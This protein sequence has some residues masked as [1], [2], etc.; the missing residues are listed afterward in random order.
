MG[1]WVIYL[2]SSQA[3]RFQ[4]K[5]LP[6][7]DVTLTITIFKSNA[8]VLTNLVAL[9]SLANLL[10]HSLSSSIYISRVYYWF[11]FYCVAWRA[12]MSNTDDLY[13][14]VK[15]TCPFVRVVRIVYCIHES[16][17]TRACVTRSLSYM[18]LPVHRKVPVAVDS[19]ES[20]GSSN[21][22]TSRCR[23]V[24]IITVSLNAHGRLSIPRSTKN[25]AWIAHG[26][27][28]IPR[29]TKN[30]AWIAHGRMSIPRSTKNNA[31]NAHRRMNIP[32]STKN[33]AWNA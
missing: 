10:K 33:Y 2:G 5:T 16:L 19:Y 15:L 20:Y 8:K 9:D 3:V 30:N 18:T 4:G 29:S 1:G 28:S 17:S 22:F 27:M 31:W 12:R 13:R 6:R 25:N 23:S 7:E 11:R 21:V 14:L 24:N 32:R 26:R